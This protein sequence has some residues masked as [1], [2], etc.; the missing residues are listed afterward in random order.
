MNIY[1]Y[2]YID[3]FIHIYIYIY[4]YLFI[5]I[6][7]YLHLIC[8][9]ILNISYKILYICNIYNTYNVHYNVKSCYANTESDLLWENKKNG[10][11]NVL[12]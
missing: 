4:I 6:Y 7:I 5:Y 12:F 8:I 3:I 2:I 10:K 1:I 11:K 9:Y